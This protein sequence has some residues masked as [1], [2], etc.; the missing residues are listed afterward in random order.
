MLLLCCLPA[1]AQQAHS[2][3]GGRGAEGTLTVTMTIVPSVG[4]MV[5]PD[6]QQ[7]LVYANTVDPRDNVSR[8]QP[9]AVPVELTPVADSVMPRKSVR[10]KKKKI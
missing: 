3:M 10:T 1:S 5:G 8:L 7:R 4:L 9:A 2:S 6:G